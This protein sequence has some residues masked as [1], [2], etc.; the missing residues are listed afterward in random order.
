MCSALLGSSH[1]LYS[2]GEC[3]LPILKVEAEALASVAQLVGF[4][5]VNLKGHGFDSRSG[6][7]PGLSVWSPEH[8]Q[9]TNNQS[10]TSVFLS[11][12]S[13]FPSL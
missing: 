11:S 1:N 9:E 3:R 2:A 12:R 4:H 10:L 8:M 13:P 7:M 5:P 6:G